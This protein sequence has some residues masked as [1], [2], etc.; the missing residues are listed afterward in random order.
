M[1]FT[2]VAYSQSVDTAGVLVEHDPLLDQHITTKGKDILVPDWAPKVV[3]VFPI[4]DNLT[5]AQLSSPSM[6]K[7]SLPDI[8]FLDIEAEPGENMKYPDMRKFPRDLVPGEGLRS[9]MAEGGAGAQRQS[10]ILLLMSEIAAMPGGV[11]ECIRCTATATLT[12][13][14]WSLATI[15]LSQQLRA[16][17]YAIVGM[18]AKSAGLIFARLVIPGSEYRPGCVGQ[19]TELQ[20]E[21]DIFQPDGMG[22]WGE[23]EHLF[24]PQIEFL[25]ISADTSEIVWL[26]VVKLS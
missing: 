2:A 23:F 13:Y 1:P 16:G 14:E 3:S 7:E 22:N 17:R 8:P 20:D 4:G 11:V 25:S 9:L 24:I 26:Y 5:Q 21:Q 6:R 19:D 10:M 18:R 12:A 15:T